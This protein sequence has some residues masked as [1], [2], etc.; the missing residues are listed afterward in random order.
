MPSSRSDNSPPRLC[1]GRFLKQASLLLLASSAIAVAQSPKSAQKK[2]ALQ[3]ANELTLAGLRPGRD[4]IAKA[5]GNF[6]TK[7]MAT[8]GEAVSWRCGDWKL[9]LDLAEKSSIRSIILTDNRLFAKHAEKPPSNEIENLPI[10]CYLKFATPLELEQGNPI[11]PK[12]VWITGKG[13]A[14]GN[15]SE[16]L[17]RIY[18]PPDSKSPSSKGGR[19][20][21]LWYYAFD[22]AGPDVPQVMEVLCTKEQGGSPGKVIEITLAAPSL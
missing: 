14:L 22:W 13:V 3:H 15:S 6:G 18:G 21:E 2:A 20:L 1:C 7:D 12:N 5:K 9:T 17:L 19:Q 11:G 4:S 10:P 16:R 8:D